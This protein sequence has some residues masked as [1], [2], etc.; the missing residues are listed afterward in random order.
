MIRYLTIFYIVTILISCQ[1]RKSLP[2]VRQGDIIFQTSRS[3]QS[4]AIQLATK[5]RYSHMGIVLF[6]DN[7]PFV[8]EAVEP[9]KYTPLAD[10]INRGAKGYAVIKRLIDAERLLTI[11]ALFKLN[12]LALQFEGKHYDLAFS[13]DDKRMY[14]S[15]LVW[16]MFDRSIGLQIGKLQRMRD[17]DLSSPVVQ[18]K[19]K[20]RYGDHFPLEEKVISP[21]AIFDSNLLITVATIN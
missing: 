8:F 11:D 18:K 10:W 14:C 3:S 6:K 1:L 15:E 21:Q 20:E 2:D 12:K 16:K 9:V 13:W 17:F 4:Q 5:S 7:K 19:L